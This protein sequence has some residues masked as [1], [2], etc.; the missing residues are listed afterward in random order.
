MPRLVAMVLSILIGSCVWAQSTT[1]KL[2]NYAGIDDY[3]GYLA[4]PSGAS[5]GPITDSVDPAIQWSVTT[6]DSEG[7]SFLRLR[8]ENLVPRDPPGAKDVKVAQL[9]INGTTFDVTVDHPYYVTARVDSEG[10]MLD[11]HIPYV[12]PKYRKIVGEIALWGPYS[13]LFAGY[14]PVADLRPG[15]AH[16][17]RP[18][19]EF[20]GWNGLAVDLG[21]V[22][23]PASL[24]CELDFQSY[25]AVATTQCYLEA[26][27]G[28]ST[29]D[30][31]DV[32]VALPDTALSLI[33]D[34]VDVAG[35]TILTL[36]ESG[37]PAPGGFQL[38]DPGSYF[39]IATTASYSGGIDLMID[40]TG[41]DFAGAPEDLHLFHYEGDQ[42]WDCTTSV[43]TLN[44][45]IYG[46]VDS[47]SPF[48]VFEPVTIPSSGPIILGAIGTVLVTHLRRRRIL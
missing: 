37:P 31:T 45:T 24:L 17:L 35:H 14:Q 44:Q 29:Q 15:S 33:Y 4:I 10:W 34:Q 48:A 46:R 40:Y 23:D 1:V 25:F 9:D 27:A 39:N 20:V 7:L 42:W 16:E 28:V 2:H 41:M 6:G 8:A 36:T 18:G 19:Y 32:S 30:G 43:D 47:L 38:G 13:S 3:Y 12:N 5:I 11:P 22:A 21:C 26:L